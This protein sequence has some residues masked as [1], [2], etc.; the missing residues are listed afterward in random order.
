AWQIDAVYTGTQ[1]CLGV[2]PGLAP[3]TFGPRAEEILAKRKPRVGSWYLDLTLIRDY[4][5]EKRV[6]HH[7]GPINMTYALHEG[8]RLISEEG[9]ANRVARHAKMAKALYAGVEG[10]GL[11]LFVQN[12]AERCPTLTTVLVPDGADDELTR[13]T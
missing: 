1:K 9:L 7:T 10:M 5:N 8:L 2:P 4:W 6:Y 3:L 12:A 11:K 13:K